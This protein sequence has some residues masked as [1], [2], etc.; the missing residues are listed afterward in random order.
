MIVF[1]DYCTTA[2][3]VSILAFQIY[4]GLCTYWIFKKIDRY[5]N[6]AFGIIER[7]LSHVHTQRTCAAENASIVSVVPTTHELGIV[8][9]SVI[10]AA[11]TVSIVPARTEVVYY[12]QRV[13]SYTPVQLQNS[14]NTHINSWYGR[15]CIDLLSLCVVK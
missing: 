9:T 10:A 11:G 4:I 5:E 3:V 6:I 15:L 12:I 14:L 13:V 1:G 8:N 7:Y 2:L